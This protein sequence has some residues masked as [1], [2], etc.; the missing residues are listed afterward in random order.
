MHKP[1]TKASKQ[2]NTLLSEP[3]ESFTSILSPIHCFHLFPVVIRE[4]P[5]KDNAILLKKCAGFGVN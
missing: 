1:N 3:F 5:S 2:E 4:H